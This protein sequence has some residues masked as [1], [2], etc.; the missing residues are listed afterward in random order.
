[1]HFG[2]QASIS[3]GLRLRRT[4]SNNTAFNKRCDELAEHLKK[5]GYKEKLILR[6]INKAKQ[7]P[8]DQALKP[9]VPKKQ[10]QPRQPVRSHLQ[11]SF[12]KPYYKQDYF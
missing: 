9:S 5:R 11:S 3:L 6:E 4:C 8:R 12:S 1:M 10:M 7:V 2:V